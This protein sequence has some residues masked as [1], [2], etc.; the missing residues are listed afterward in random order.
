[1][2]VY[3]RLLAA[4]VAIALLLPVAASAQSVPDREPIETRARDAW[5]ELGNDIEA[6]AAYAAA[7]EA[8]RGMA[9]PVPSAEFTSSFGAPRSG[10]TH[11]G[12]DMMA[13]F[14]TEVLAPE[15]GTFEGDGESF[16]LYADSGT[17]YFGTHNGGDLVGPGR[18]ERGQ[19]I[20]TVSNT[21][22]ASGG[23]PHLHF[24]IHPNDGEA[25]DPYPLTYEACSAP[26]TFQNPESSAVT[27]AR[28]PM[29]PTYRYGIMEIHR[30]ANAT[31]GRITPLQARFLTRYL[32]TVVTNQLRRF[33]AAIAS[34]PYEAN[35]DR[36]AACESG[37]NW[38][39]NT[40][41]GYYGG[42][43]FSLATWQSVGGIGYPH[44]NSKREQI[45]RA[46][47]LRQRSGLGQWPH[48]GPRW[49]G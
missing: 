36:V 26:A 12:V 45:H 48:C 18:V 33:Y 6:G 23:S 46:E 39:I 24:E 5:A 25:I 15:A 29:T 20:S 13:D 19:P 8:N 44:Q 11:Q 3:V 34:I 43:Q 1:M 47:I 40:G 16:Y 38:S 30:W 2:R 41:N 27:T 4:S 9:C 32:N 42:V 14:G 22:N 35:W 31:Y 28:I 7:V 21:G 17:T 37:G 10:H 49:Y